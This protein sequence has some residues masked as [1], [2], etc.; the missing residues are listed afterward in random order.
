MRIIILDTETTGLPIG[1]NPPITT[2]ALWPH[3]V[4]FSYIIFNTETN[5]LENTIDCIIKLPED[6]I[7]DAKCVEI[8]GISNEISASY[9][10]S[11]G[12]V[13]S[14]FLEDLNRVDLVVAHNM[15]FDK[16]VILAELIRTRSLYKIHSSSYEY[17]DNQITE[18]IHSSKLYCTMQESTDLCKIVRMN[19]FK[20][21]YHKFPTLSE[22]HIHLFGQTPQKLHNA[23]NDVII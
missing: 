3:I 16:N 13:L 18:L 2:P 5:D 8:H 21:P 20:Q 11:I 22:L 12:G 4:Q 10:I 7:M 17:L 23:L 1:R 14:T 19:K 6:I 9:G 15:D